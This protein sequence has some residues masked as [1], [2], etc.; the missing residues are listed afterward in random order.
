MTSI[1]T[2][3]A[4][5]TATTPPPDS[6]PKASLFCPDCGHE[7][8]ITGDWLVEQGDGDRTYRCPECQSAISTRDDSR[9]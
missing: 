6:R 5:A 7:S 4:Y 8:P 2:Y 1:D 9:N 3:P